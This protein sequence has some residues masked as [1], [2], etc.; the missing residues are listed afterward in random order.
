MT[1]IAGIELDTIG[2]TQYAVSGERGKWVVADITPF[3]SG[4][5]FIGG[6]YRTKSEAWAAAKADAQGRTAN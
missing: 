2:G 5:R 1:K 3:K 4:A 6:E